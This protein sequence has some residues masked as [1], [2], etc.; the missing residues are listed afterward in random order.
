MYLNRPGELGPC[1]GGSRQ[2]GVL[3]RGRELGQG[4]VQG[5][6]SIPWE[7]NARRTQLKNITFLQL[8][9]HINKT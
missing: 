6:P 9:W 1:T 4:P 8:R 7:Q 5:H 3:Y 2:A